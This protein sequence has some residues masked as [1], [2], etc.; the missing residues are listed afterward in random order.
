MTNLPQTQGYVSVI[1][2]GFLHPIISLLE[3]LDAN[4]P[5]GPN[6]VHASD[7]ENGYSV[8]IIVLSV[9][10]VESA[11]NRTHY[12]LG[13]KPIKN[14]VLFVKHHFPMFDAPEKLEELFVVRDVIAHNHIWE[15]QFYWDEKIGMKLISAKLHEEFGDRK[16]KRV[17]NID[18]RS[19]KVLN[20]NLFPTRICRKDCIVVLKNTVEFLLFLEKQ[21]RN[22][23]YLSPQYVN[24]KGDY[25]NFVQIV[26]EVDP[27]T[28]ISHNKIVWKKG[29]NDK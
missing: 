9:L 16:Y 19:T 29:N 25:V 2:T 28:T 27:I 13:N 7:L 6:E 22:Y 17:I 3:A 5:I 26:N 4:N 15:A 20:I 1:G 14:P 12:I 21:D 23:I 11:I 18:N 24:Y 8:A 10:L